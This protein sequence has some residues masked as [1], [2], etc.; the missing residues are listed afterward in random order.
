LSV[1]FNYKVWNNS[2]SYEII[3]IILNLI[4]GVWQKFINLILGVWQ[5]F[6]NYEEYMKK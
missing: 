2:E 1:N 4:L 6:I 5:K 3:R